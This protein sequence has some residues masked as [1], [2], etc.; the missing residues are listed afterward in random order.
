MRIGRI[1]LF[2]LPLTAVIFS[3][4]RE[5][6]IKDHDE[7]S[8]Y[9]TD[10]GIQKS[11]FILRDNNHESIHYYNKDRCLERFSPASTFKIFNSLVA[12]ETGIAPDEQM[13]IKWD[14]VVRSKPEWN[15]DM[16]MREAFKLSNVGYFQ[17]LARRI[18]PNLMQHYIDTAKYGNMRIGGAIDQFWLNDTLKIS[19]D[20]Q[21]GFVKRLY[22]NELPFSERSQR[23]VRSMMLREDTAGYKLYYKTGWSDLPGRQLLWIVGFAEREVSVK[24]PKESMNKGNM[25]AYPYFFAEN[26]E[27]PNGDTTKDWAKIRLDIVHNILRDYGAIN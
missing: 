23:I 25:R 26:F 3:S 4:C 27:I 11:C 24:E 20:E 21:L 15:K 12:L 16:N 1:F 10:N 22:F 2:L 17:E 13:V 8:K 14:S 9:F 18:G 5:S 7:W 6:R 19:A